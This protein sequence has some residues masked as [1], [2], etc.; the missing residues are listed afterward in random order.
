ML[1]ENYKSKKIDWYGLSK[2]KSES[3]FLDK[4]NNYRCICLRVP[5]IF[6]PNLKRNSPLIIKI[7]RK[8]IKNQT[9]TLYNPNSSFNNITDA[10]DIYKVIKIFLNSKKY[11]WIL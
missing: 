10:E 3:I 2:R 5:G 4:K 6:V 7:I 11:F 8:L 1:N 9:V